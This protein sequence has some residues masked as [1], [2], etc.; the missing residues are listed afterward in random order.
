[1]LEQTAARTGVTRSTHCKNAKQ[2]MPMA[3]RIEV[4]CVNKT[5]RPDPHERIKAIGGGS[6]GQQWK[7]TQEQAITWIEEGTFAYYVDK[8]GHEVDLIVAVSQHGH[9]YLKTTADGE[10]PNNLLSLPECP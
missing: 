10:Q 1:M 5:D 8:G 6:I 7:Q 4:N 3:T 9:K 2:D